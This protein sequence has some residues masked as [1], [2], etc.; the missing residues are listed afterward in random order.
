MN[1]KEF[2]EYMDKQLEGLTLQQQIKE[3]KKINENY[4]PSLIQSRQKKLGLW[5]DPKEQ[6]KYFFC[7]KCGRYYLTKDCKENMVR[8]VHTETTYTDAGYGDDDKTGDVEYMV[9]Y[10]MS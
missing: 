6:H 9:T 3:L 7:K 5:V 8:E 1:K 4:L 10:Y 2:A